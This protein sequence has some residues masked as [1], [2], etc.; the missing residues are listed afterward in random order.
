MLETSPE[1][2]LSNVAST[3]TELNCPTDV[4]KMVREL[5]KR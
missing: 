1:I 2:A 4:N 5:R 3:K